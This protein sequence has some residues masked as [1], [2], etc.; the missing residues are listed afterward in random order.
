M[1]KILLLL[2]APLVILSAC[3]KKD[4][5]VD[6]AKQA[7][8]DDATIQAY[9]KAHT[10]INATK[11]PS[12]LYYQIITPGTGAN[13]TVSSTITVNYTGKLLDGTTFETGTA[14][15]ATLNGLITGWKIGIPL[16][17]PGGR[18]LLLIPSGLAYG[19][20]ANSGI[21]A[22]SVLQFTIDLTGF[23]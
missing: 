16:I 9:L 21:P 18:I 8:A 5:N 6:P 20:Q 7:A 10:E 2:F 14:F 15:T 13:P 11:D 4:S 19:S 22:N 12:G 3:S 1:K 17:K 23:K